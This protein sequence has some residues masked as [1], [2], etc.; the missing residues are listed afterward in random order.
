MNF[1]KDCEH[2]RKGDVDWYQSDW[3]AARVEE[4]DLVTGYQ[5]YPSC[6]N[7]RGQTPDCPDYEARLTRKERNRRRKEA[8]EA[9]DD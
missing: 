8:K 9:S 4:I 2:Y 3:C 5:S 6:C 1:C 7:R